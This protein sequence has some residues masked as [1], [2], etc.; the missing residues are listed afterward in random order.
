MACKSSVPVECSLCG[1]FSPN[2]TQH[3]SHLRLVHSQDPNFSTDCGIGSCS[4]RFS[5]FA[6]FNTHIYR[7]HRSEL[8][9]QLTVPLTLNTPLTAEEFLG[10]R[11]D[12]EIV[13]SF[14]RRSD[15]EFSSTYTC[16][17]C[18]EASHKEI[19]AKLLLSLTEGHRLS[20]VAVQDVIAGCRNV[21]TQTATHLTEVVRNKL[22][23]LEVDFSVIEQV[24]Q[25]ITNSV[26]DPFEGL[27]T[28]HFRNKYFKEQFHYLV[29]NCDCLGITLE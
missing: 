11:D 8:G 2:L 15:Q 9:L 26:V 5:T 22:I 6:A 19:N 27:G 29:S 28:S 4:K 7:H 12:Q 18:P 23:E 16:T 14:D 3:V 20:E 21:S 17:Y 25:E 13:S 1:F 10:V 24:D